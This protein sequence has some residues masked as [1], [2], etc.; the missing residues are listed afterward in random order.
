MSIK[1]DVL[2][3]GYYGFGNAGDEAILEAAV[4]ALKN[5]GLQVAVL[6]HTPEKTKL[7]FQV[8][9]YHRKN[10][11]QVL[12][13]IQRS[14][15]IL[16]GGGGLFQDTTSFKSLLYYLRIPFV[17]KLLGKKTMIFA[18]G[19]GPISS[20]LGR[21]F[22]RMVSNHFIDKITVRDEP[23]KLL[24]KSLG[25]RKSIE[26]TAD[27]AFLFPLPQEEARNEARLRWSLP[28]G[29][30]A[31]FGLVIRHWPGIEASIPS[32][33]KSISA[34][35]TNQQ[36]LPVLFPFQASRDKELTQLLSHSLAV[37]HVTIL[38]ALTPSELLSVISNLELLVAM[39]Y[40]AILFAARS[41]VP[42]IAISY[43]DKVRN[44]AESLACPTLTLD[45]LSSHNLA[46]TLSQIWQNRNQYRKHL[47]ISVE[48]IAKKAM[49]NID[50][51]LELLGNK[52]RSL[53]SA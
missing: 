39:R 36:A 19:I 42:S 52:G 38:D 31:L 48:P 20:T 14:K 44:L 10:F 11:S 34:F 3:S 37:P 22:T 5:H 23:S 25:V 47:E 49:G 41:H 33:T 6:T 28:E 50:L 8:E 17:A 45:E 12:R 32:L 18:Q 46:D 16:S 29:S 24:L 13:A 35:A 4:F 43:D 27:L 30:K 1:H 26:V 2:L 40:H 21:Y 9:T 15:L 51:V 7:D 53:H